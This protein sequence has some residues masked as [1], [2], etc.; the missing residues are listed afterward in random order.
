MDTQQ[1]GIDAIPLALERVQLAQTRD[2]LVGIAPFALGLGVV[3]VLI[4]AV[5][6]GMRLR[7]RG[8][9]RPSRPG[10]KRPRRTRGYDEGYPAASPRVPRDGER[11]M[12]YELSGHQEEG[13]EEEDEPPPRHHR[14]GAFGSG[15]PGPT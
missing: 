6:Y 3:A 1:L 10:P 14:S 12:P 11:R 7:D 2:F 9:T 5:M 4:L 13:A 8:D 15:G